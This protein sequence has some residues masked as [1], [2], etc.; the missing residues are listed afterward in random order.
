MRAGVCICRIIFLT[1][2]SNNHNASFP[3]VLSFS[4]F[5]ALH[6][7]RRARSALSCYLPLLISFPMPSFLWALPI[8]SALGGIG[9]QGS[10]LLWALAGAVVVDHARSA[11]CQSKGSGPGLVPL[12]TR[13]RSWGEGGVRSLPH[14][15]CQVS[16]DTSPRA[17]GALGVFSGLSCAVLC[18]AALYCCC[19]GVHIPPL[20][21]SVLLRRWRGC[22]GSRWGVVCVGG[23]IVH[24]E[25]CQRC[26]W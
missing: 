5:C 23:G 6:R 1:R 14:R 7:F 4:S 17:R 13:P 16:V 12:Y 2:A 8:L 22:R 25:W 24:S 19:M 11:R 9:W 3:F 26:S 15:P 18:W 20:L 21:V 10:V